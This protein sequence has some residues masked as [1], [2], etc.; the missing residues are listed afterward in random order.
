M[1][2]IGGDV[3]G[4]HPHRVAGD[5]PIL[6]EGLFRKEDPARQPERRVQ[7]GVEV[8][9]EP[10]VVDAERPQHA[11]GLGPVE[12]LGRLQRLGAAVAQQEAAIR[13]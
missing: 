10:V 6:A 5:E 12:R 3:V 7:V 11:L 9:L 8:P 2:A 1:H 13:P 4:D